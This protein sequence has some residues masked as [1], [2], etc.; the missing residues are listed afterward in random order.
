MLEQIIR[1]FAQDQIL[2][3]FT[4]LLVLAGLL[5]VI[6]KIMKS[7]IE[8][9]AK[10]LEVRYNKIKSVPLQ[11]KLN[12][13]LA[14]S[15][16]NQPLIPIVEKA[17]KTHQEISETFK[18]IATLL[19]DVEDYLLMGRLKQGRLGLVDI[20]E[21]LV[22]NE[23]QVTQ[24]DQQ[25]SDLL[26][27]E[28]TQRSTITQLKD[29]FRKIKATLINDSA[30]YSLALDTLQQSLMDV[31]KMFSAFEE[32]MF[33]SEFEKA[34][35]KTKEIA[36]HITQ[37]QQQLELL[38]KLITQVKGVIPKMIDDVAYS[39]T[40][41]KQKGVSIQHLDVARN[42]E[43]ISNTLKE[44]LANLRLAI[45]KDIQ[46]H[47]DASLTRLNQLKTA[48]E[49]EDKAFDEQVVVADELFSLMEQN[50]QTYQIL[51][52]QAT[53]HGE[54][55]DIKE[56][57]E[58]LPILES[59][60]LENK[61]IAFKLKQLIKENTIPATTIILSLKDALAQVSANQKLLDSHLKTLENHLTEESRAQKQ[62][63]KLQL[64][65]NEIKVKIRKHRL[66]AI[67]DSYKGDVIKSKQMIAKL[68]ETLDSKPID[69]EKLNQRVNESIDFV[70]KLYNLVN[71]IVGMVD[72]IEHAIVYANKYR[73]TYPIID[74]E[75]TRTELM[76]RNGE[77]T[78]ALTT[79]LSAIERLHPDSF[80]QL[81]RE[82]AKSARS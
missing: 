70:Y 61:D 72:M 47:V 35:A 59:K 77:Y 33:A 55:F 13:A 63:L 81:V 73:S 69:T 57:S 50:Q 64:I 43:M 40:R 4:G 45:T 24:L 6:R 22:I 51:N 10:A 46:E 68:Q 48:C 80:E 7:K 38:P 44:D 39:A 71:N 37:L 8:K 78:Q 15:K 65:I 21:L 14:L 9:Q 18:A 53:K 42:L 52:E 23:K 32:W 16:V 36:T 74:T 34:S 66:P 75:C 17:Q 31:E 67:S 20:E 1:F 49:H 12:K 29:D 60:L 62:L 82:N 54:R 56:I 41:L 5:L 30:S 79:I 11:F 76:F 2:I 25:L 19:A 58:A 26:E 3:V 27:E 28:T